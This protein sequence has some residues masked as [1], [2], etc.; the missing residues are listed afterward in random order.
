ML[1]HEHR[2]DRQ[3]VTVVEA[4]MNRPPPPALDDPEVWAMES[5]D[6]AVR[7]LLPNGGDVDEGYFRAEA[8]VMESRL[9]MAA[10]RL[11]AI[12]NRALPTSTVR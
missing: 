9:A 11:A 1:L 5:H 3:E 8:P 4:L 2:S 6:A 12:L 7:A 10:L